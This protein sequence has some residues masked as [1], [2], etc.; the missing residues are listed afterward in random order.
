MQFIYYLAGNIVQLCAAYAPRIR[1]RMGERDREREEKED[2][3]DLTC[4][5]GAIFHF[6]IDSTHMW[7]RQFV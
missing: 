3:N 7:Q 6:T 2:N 5:Y 4:G 1:K